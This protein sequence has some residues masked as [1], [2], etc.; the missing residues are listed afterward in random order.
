SVRTQGCPAAQCL[1]ALEP[2]PGAGDPVLAGMLVFV[3]S[4]VEE[5]LVLHIAVSETHGR[6]RRSGMAVARRLI[7]ELRASA[8]RLRGV[9]W[10]RLLYT[11]D[12]QFQ[13]RVG[14]RTDPASREASHGLARLAS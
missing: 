8:R 11:G 5:L 2:Q 13:I 6:T 9:R 7:R 1:F 4:S 10:V 12:R 3:R 14:S